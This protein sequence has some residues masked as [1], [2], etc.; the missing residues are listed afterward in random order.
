MITMMIK[1]PN[2]YREW[3]KVQN[4]RVTSG[5]FWPQID[6][7]DYNQDK[8]LQRQYSCMMCT[9]YSG[10]IIAPLRG[11]NII[12]TPSSLSILM[13]CGIALNAPVE[14]TFISQVK[15]NSPPSLTHISCGMLMNWVLCGLPIYC[16]VKKS[17]L[18]LRIGIISLPCVFTYTCTCSFSLWIKGPE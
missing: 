3:R 4:E 2:F 11:E 1:F 17:C 12:L 14:S 16:S 8:Q 7:Q 18:K 15:F 13:D 5:I 10:V 6:I 9:H